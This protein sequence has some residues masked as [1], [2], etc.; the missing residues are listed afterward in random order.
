MT[1]KFT[2]NLI[3]A[4]AALIFLFLI[5]VIWILQGSLTG[6]KIAYLKYVPI[7]MAIVSGNPVFAGD[8]LDFKE[9]VNSSNYSNEAIFLAALNNRRYEILVNNF[10]ANYNLELANSDLNKNLQKFYLNKSS[11]R[12]YY[13]S[14]KNLNAVT[15]QKAEDLLRRARNRE[16]F[17]A[18]VQSYSQDEFSKN[19]G[20][21]L[22]KMETENLLPEI[23]NRVKDMNEG[24]VELIASREGL[25]IIQLS[26]KQDSVVELKQIFLNVPGFE[27]WLNN[28]LKEIK[29]KIII[30][31]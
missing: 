28:Q 21:E 17:E 3:I 5:S 19:L 26:K 31:P 4:V 22:G 29:T 27:D 10:N 9:I 1:K 6:A 12:I 24:Q 11:L 18:L 23:A 15:F 14:Q 30:N 2:K 16:N 25:H 8:Y 13:N 7:P 20:G